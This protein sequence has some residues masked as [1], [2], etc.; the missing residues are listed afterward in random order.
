M[1]IYLKNSH[2]KFHPERLHIAL[3]QRR[4][5]ITPLCSD[6]FEVWRNIYFKCT[7]NNNI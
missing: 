6:T 5:V 1:S 2:A 4:A 7:R 3:E